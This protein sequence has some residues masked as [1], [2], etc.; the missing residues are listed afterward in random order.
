MPKYTAVYSESSTAQ[1]ED[2][3]YYV[4]EVLDQA[5]FN[6]YIMA[7]RKRPSFGSLYGQTTQ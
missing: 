2:M 6:T 7:D 4:P 1:I 5:A 3:V